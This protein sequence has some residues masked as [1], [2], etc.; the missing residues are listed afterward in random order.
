MAG[1]A[2]PS[3]PRRGGKGDRG[4]TSSGGGGGGRVC[5]VRNHEFP[6]SL[7]SPPL[8]FSHEEL[9]NVVFQVIVIPSFLISGKFCIRS[10]RVE[11]R[12]ACSLLALSLSFRLFTHCSLARSPVSPSTFS[13]SPAFTLASQAAHS[14]AITSP[15]VSHSSPSRRTSSLLAHPHA[16]AHTRTH[17]HRE[18]Q[19]TR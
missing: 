18:M 1:G 16:R 2:G 7:L 14:H 19:G 6:P 5:I 13:L 4:T 8:A 17:T 12:S 9:L 15:Y 11:R 10:A 3:R